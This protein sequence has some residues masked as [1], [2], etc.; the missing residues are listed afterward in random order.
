M[1]SRTR[2][3]SRSAAVVAAAG[4]CAVFA[5]LL[6]AS[7]VQA[8]GG[9][10]VNF[11]AH[12]K[13]SGEAPDDPIVLPRLPGS[14]HDHTFF[15]NERIDAFS[16]LQSLRGN[17]TTCNRRSDTAAYWVPTLYKNHRS[18]KPLDAVA[19]YTLREHSHVR[20][21][22]PGLKVVAGDAYA[23]K[24]QPLHIVWW[25]CAVPG[26]VT[27]AATP[28]ADCGAATIRAHV[29]KTILSAR[30]RPGTLR[31]GIQLHLRFP[32][33]W[34]GRHLD[35]ADHQGHMAY[36]SSEVCPSDHPV[37][38]PSLILIVTYPI[39]SGR[40]TTL[41]SGGQLTGHGDFFNAWKE[42]ALRQ[43]VQ[44]CVAGRPLCGRH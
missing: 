22:P 3:R 20:P 24:P 16:T 21:Y 6:T 9:P 31:V 39:P 17:G 7:C 4:L 1:A 2:R 8:A 25:T 27:A 43:I 12:C 28:P 40:G 23:S 11:L 37:Q 44:D 10:L 34:D 41:A 38:L 15:G 13:V 33:C 29:S 30:P 36:S 19:Y 32:D 26:V 42:P 18:V 14:S 5:G 35:S